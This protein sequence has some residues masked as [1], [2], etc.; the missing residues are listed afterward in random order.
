L[1]GNRPFA[2]WFVQVA[3]SFQSKKGDRSISELKRN[4]V[5]SQ[6]PDACLHTPKAENSRNQVILLLFTP[7]SKSVVSFGSG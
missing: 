6:R 5:L 4:R 7:S 2:S 1:N 3:Y